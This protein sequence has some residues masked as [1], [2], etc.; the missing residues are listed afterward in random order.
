MRSST[1]LVALTALNEIGAISAYDHDIALT[2]DGYVCA[3]GDN[4]YGAARP[5]STQRIVPA[6]APVMQDDG[7]TPLKLLGNRNA[8][9]KEKSMICGGEQ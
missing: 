4:S 6:P 2:R 7:K 5:D 3:W 9:G 8:D 1:T